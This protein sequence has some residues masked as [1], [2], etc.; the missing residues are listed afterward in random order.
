MLRTH[1]LTVVVA[2]ILLVP[3]CGGLERLGCSG[4]YN[5]CVSSIK[6]YRK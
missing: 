1:T 2:A 5:D 6:V 4:S 3:A